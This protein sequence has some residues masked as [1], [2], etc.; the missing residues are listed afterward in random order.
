MNDEK[1]LIPVHREGEQQ[2][3]EGEMRPPETTLS[4]DTFAAKIQFKWSPEA[5]VRSLGRCRCSSNF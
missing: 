5:D 2:E 1:A 3:Q 4:L